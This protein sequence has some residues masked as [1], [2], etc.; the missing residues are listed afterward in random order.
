MEA[1]LT[2]I[3][4]RLG[5]ATGLGLLVGL[6]REGADSSIAGF[7]TFAL[8]ALL[9]AFSALLA[10]VYGGWIL[11]AGVLAVGA[12]VVMGNLVKLQAGI[13]DPG[14]TTEVAVLLTF[15]LGAYLMVGQI[16]VGIVA[17]GALAVLLQLKS[18]ARRL[19]EWLGDRDVEA[20]VRFALLTLVIL[21]VLPNQTYG[22]FDVLNPRHIWLMVVLIVGIGFGGYLAYK[23]LGTRAGSALSGLLGGM[24]SSTATTVSHAQRGRANEQEARVA[25]VVIV[26]ASSIVFVRVLVEIAVVAPEAMVVAGPP[27]AAV[28]GAFLALAALAWHRQP[29]EAGPMPEQDNPTRLGPALAFGLLYGAILLAVAAGQEWFGDQGLY[30]IAL[31]SGLAD[32]DAITLS[33]ASLTRE[34]RVSED[35][36]WR[37]VLVAAMANLVFKLGVCRIMGGPVLTRHV[38]P[39]YAA[40]AAFIGAVLVFWP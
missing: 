34:G 39:W 10:Q 16:E 18:R 27:I 14:L 32:M 19:V 1:E 29:D 8:L 24:I 37:V 26:V 4:A 20:V 30:V 11:A 28:L 5:I 2:S 38:L 6:Q 40:G 23:A 25:T 22:P 35:M 17:G 12:F 3:L 9:G 36:L 15:V 21:P 31:L 33:T 13:Q 7:R